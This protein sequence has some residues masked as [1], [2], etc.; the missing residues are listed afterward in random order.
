MELFY[1]HITLYA[2]SHFIMVYILTV[3][4]K[5]GLWKTKCCVR[6]YFIHKV[7]IISPN[8]ST[9]LDP[10]GFLVLDWNWQT[11]IDLVDDVPILG[12][13]MLFYINV[14]RIS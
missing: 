4:K 12:A 13:H 9:L 8:T 3:I 7:W 14:Y 11:L 2:Y 10:V 5:L 6:D 1:I